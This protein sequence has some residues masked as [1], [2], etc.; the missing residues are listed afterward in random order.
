M[1]RLMASSKAWLSCS[2]VSLPNDNPKWD[3]KPEFP[4]LQEE[5]FPGRRPAESLLPG[6]A[7]QSMMKAIHTRGGR[8]LCSMPMCAPAVFQARP[9]RFVARVLLDGKEETV[10]VKN[11]GRCRELLVP[12]ARVY[13]AEGDNPARKTRYDLVAVGKRGAA[14]ES[15]FPGAQQGVCPVGAGRRIPPRPDA[16]APRD[17]LGQFPV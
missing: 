15:G 2:M 1:A 7:K 17:H 4:F 16:A 8:R 11:T 6:G 5:I 13:L 3:Y 9:N 10:H 12:G 14:G